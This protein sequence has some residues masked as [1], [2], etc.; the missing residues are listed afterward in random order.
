MQVRFLVISGLVLFIVPSTGCQAARQTAAIHR[1]P[2]ANIAPD[3]AGWQSTSQ[4]A[5]HGGSALQYARTLNGQGHIG[6]PAFLVADGVSIDEAE[7]IAL[8]LNADLRA[9]RMKARIPEAGA[10]HAGLPDDPRFEFDLLQILEGI[11]TPWILAGGLSYTYPLA[12]RLEGERF[13]ALAKA[14]TAIRE[15]H[16]AERK[17]LLKLREAWAAWSKTIERVALIE[18][19]RESV[20]KIVKFATVQRDAEQIGAPEVRVLELEAKTRQGEILA[21]RHKAGGQLLRLKRLMGLTPQAP[22]Q[23]VPDLGIRPATCDATTER[24]QIEHVSVDVLLA[25]AEFVEADRALRHEVSKR[26]PDLELG[27]ML[28][29]EEGIGRLGLGMGIDLPIWNK[30][31][32]AIAEACATRAAARAIYQARYQ[33]AVHDLAEAHADAQ[34]AAVRATWI[35]NEV[36]PLADQQLKQLKKLGEIGDMDVLILTDALAKV[37]DTKLQLLDAR[38]DHVAADLRRRA[39]TEPLR[40]T[41]AT[42]RSR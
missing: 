36:A 42:L 9:A 30:N 26:F 39:L 19:H 17:L 15:V 37:L 21:L 41:Y 31:K 2:D 33:Q 34:T 22:I 13:E 3:D 25:K 24:T 23:A 8:F 10:R 32:R 27:P 40:P 28:G 20:N 18:A 4:Q 35:S 38:A 12:G 29:S 16:V 7:A 14:N 5:L 11:N 1:A 6:V